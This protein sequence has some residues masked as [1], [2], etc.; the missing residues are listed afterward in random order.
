M[1]LLRFIGYGIVF[2]LVPE[3]TNLVIINNTPAGFVGA[4]A[5][6]CVLLLLGY[7]VQKLI[8]R[9]FHGAVLRNVLCIVFFGLFGLS[10]EW[11]VIGNSPWKNPNAIQW[12]MFVYWVGLYMIP[13]ILVDDREVVRGLARWI[14]LIYLVYSAVHLLLSLTMPTH[15]LIVLVPVMWTIVYSGFGAFYLKYIRILNKPG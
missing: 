4:L 2:A 7:G 5:V 10:F 13:R 1:R 8:D 15:V 9:L 6:Y 3:F 11:I 12:G 14:T